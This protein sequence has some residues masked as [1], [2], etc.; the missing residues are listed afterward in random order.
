MATSGENCNYRP[1]TIKGAYW[2][3]LLQTGLQAYH[4]VEELPHLKHNVLLIVFQ[5]M[6]ISKQFIFAVF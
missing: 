6:P 4:D 3:P 5:E 2:W 1:V